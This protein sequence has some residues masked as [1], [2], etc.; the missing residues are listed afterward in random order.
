[1][2]LSTVATRSAIRVEDLHLAGVPDSMDPIW[3]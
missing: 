3:E 1:M 2:F